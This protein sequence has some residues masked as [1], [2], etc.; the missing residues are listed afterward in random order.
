MLVNYKSSILVNM[1]MFY[2][3]LP[4][5]VLNQNKMPRFYVIDWLD[6]PRLLTFIDS[7]QWES[8]SPA[9]TENSLNGMLVVRLRSVTQ[10]KI[11]G[12]GHGPSQHIQ[13]P[14]TAN[15]VR[16]TRIIR[17]HGHFDEFKSCLSFANQILGLSNV[18]S[19]VSNTRLTLFSWDIQ[20]DELKVANFK[21]QIG[22]TSKNFGTFPPV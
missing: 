16:H 21:S 13:T 18:L 10:G 15:R 5:S 2:I 17:K 3:L 22:C 4:R 12:T 1:Y 8:L 6:V 7:L 9:G 11:R 19:K 14:G 20:Q